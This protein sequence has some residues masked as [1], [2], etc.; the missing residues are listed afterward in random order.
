MFVRFAKKKI[1][2]LLIQDRQK[3]VQQLEGEGFVVVKGKK[4]LL[5]SKEFSFKN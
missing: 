4:D 3:M 1:P 2:L 5:L